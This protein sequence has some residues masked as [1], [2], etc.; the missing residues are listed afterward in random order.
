MF[1]E[2][3]QTEFEEQMQ[4]IL[5]AADTINEQEV[6]KCKVSEAEEAKH[7]ESGN[8][9]TL[10]TSQEVDGRVQEGEESDTQ[11]KTKL[12][13][14]AREMELELERMVTGDRALLKVEV[15]RSEV[16]LEELEQ[17]QA[18]Q[19]KARCTILSQEAHRLVGCLGLHLDSFNGLLPSEMQ[20][21]AEKLNTIQ[22]AVLKPEDRAV[23]VGGQASEGVEEALSSTV[24]QL[25]GISAT[26]GQLQARVLTR[27]EQLTRENRHIHTL[28]AVKRGDVDPVGEHFC[29][30]H[31]QQLQDLKVA[32]AGETSRLQKGC[33]SQLE[34]IQTQ[35]A[36]EMVA[37]Q[38]EFRQYRRTVEE[39][40]T[41]RQNTESQ[42]IISLQS[43]VLQLQ[44]A[45]QAGSV[46]DDA[47]ME[48]LILAMRQELDSLKHMH[49]Q[50]L[51]RMQQ[52]HEQSMHHEQSLHAAALEAAQIQHKAMLSSMA[53][54]HAQEM[55][56]SQQQNDNTIQQLRRELEQMT[57]GDQTLESE[58]AASRESYP[59]AA[60]EM[61]DSTATE[62]QELETGPRSI[63]L[64]NKTRRIDFTQSKP[65]DKPRDQALRG[66]EKVASILVGDDDSWQ[67][68][69]AQALAHVSKK[70]VNRRGRGS[71]NDIKP[72]FRKD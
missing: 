29:N 43:Q 16:A 4:E 53:S 69:A 9:D 70:L 47:R 56:N 5:D 55:K 52:Q 30:D 41:Q 45:A 22:N 31:T 46:S 68:A 71:A 15:L 1:G 48:Q 14:A 72:D 42:E 65:S 27:M 60:K 12:V 58:L 59:V 34:L 64:Q 50:E 63:G 2:F 13:Q 11:A 18:L 40:L 23:I 62:K 20:I 19:Q 25:H 54:H 8:P 37:V 57:L 61:M 36:S 7:S 66:A 26:M 51:H 39:N 17:A 67:V 35:H 38:D 21:S 24:L 3:T 33:A 6:A 28:D 44:E 49:K 10:S 32:H